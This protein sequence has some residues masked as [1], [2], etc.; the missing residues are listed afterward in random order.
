MKTKLIKLEELNLPFDELTLTDDEMLVAK[1]AAG[2]MP[3]SS[4]SGCNCGCSTSK[5][6][7]TITLSLLII[8]WLSPK[9]IGK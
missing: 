8:I 2:I 6:R 7:W 3:F 4:G 1:G 5:C 9:K